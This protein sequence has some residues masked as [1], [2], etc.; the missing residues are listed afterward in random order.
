MCSFKFFT[1]DSV[2]SVSSKTS[3]CVKQMFGAVEKT[4]VHDRNEMKPKQKQCISNTQWLALAVTARCSPAFRAPSSGSV[5]ERPLCQRLLYLG[6]H[7]R[8]FPS[9]PRDRVM[10]LCC[11]MSAF[12]ERGNETSVTVFEHK[13][14]LK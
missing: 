4:T 11:L 7:V 12:C 1:C 10:S 9:P 3:V 5:I 13:E 2:F 8:F 14:D 6:V